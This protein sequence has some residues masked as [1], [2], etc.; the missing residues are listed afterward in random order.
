MLVVLSA[1]SHEREADHQAGEDR[2]STA[3]ERGVGDPIAGCSR[4]VTQLR[5]DHAVRISCED[6]EISVPLPRGRL[7]E[8]AL[9]IIR[10]HEAD[11]ESG[12]NPVYWFRFITTISS[13]P[14]PDG[15]GG[16]LKVS[17]SVKVSGRYF[18]RG[19]GLRTFDAVVLG[20]RPG[21]AALALEMRS[22]RSWIFVDLP[23]LPPLQTMF[24]EADV[25]L[26]ARGEVV[27]RGDDPRHV[28]YRAAMSAQVEVEDLARVESPRG[29][30]SGG[31][32]GTGTAD[33]PMVIPIYVGESVGWKL[34]DCP[35][36]P[37]VSPGECRTLRVAAAADAY[38]FVSLRTQ[39]TEFVIDELRIGSTLVLRSVP[40]AKM[41]RLTTGETWILLPAPHDGKDEIYLRV[42][43]WGRSP[44]N[45]FMAMMICRDLPSGARLLDL[46]VTGILP[47]STESAT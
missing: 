31:R 15:E 8:D 46:R 43:N 10:A 41:V 2:S 13:D 39:S 18:V 36:L 24:E 29:D 22:R 38:R 32:A 12:T 30:R 20:R 25:L 34:W 11:Q 16:W 23:S 9:R 3:V 21:E 40:S 44:A 35:D 7:V 42:T 45:F 17:P 28:A 26:D 5:T 33:H 37:P 47:E 4:P 6:E 14:V 19:T 27:E 1:M